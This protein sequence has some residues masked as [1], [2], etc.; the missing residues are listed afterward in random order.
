[1]TTTQLCVCLC[2]SKEGAAQP[3]A[4]LVCALRRHTGWGSGLCCAFF[5][6]ICC[7]DRLQVVMAQKGRAQVSSVLAT[8]VGCQKTVERFWKK[9]SFYERCEARDL[10]ANALRGA[11]H[12]RDVRTQKR[13]R[14]APPMGRSVL[15]ILCAHT[16]GSAGG[17]CGGRR[18]EQLSGAARWARSCA[19]CRPA[20][21]G[22]RTG[23]WKL[24]A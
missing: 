9:S 17:L 20:V 5:A 8:L 7:R 6:L 18:T 4:W 15:R 24:A 1:M 13:F 2:N 12:E 16:I 3:T 10:C 19:P 22:R 21:L 11:P 14:T 23:H